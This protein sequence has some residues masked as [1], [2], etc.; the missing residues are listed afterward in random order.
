LD[1]GEVI[2][3]NQWTGG[4]ELDGLLNAEAS[5]VE[6][7][8]FD[9]WE[10]T[11]ATPNPDNKAPSITLAVEDYEEIV[12]YFR[13]VEFA[14]Y[15][16]TAFSPNNDGLNDA[17]LPVGNAFKTETY[18]LVVMNR[19]GEVVFESMDPEEPWIGQYQSGD[20]F[21][22]DGLYMFTLEVQSVHELAVRRING[23]VSVVR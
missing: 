17:F 20:H 5:P 6:F 7:W 10:T 15:V 1:G 14:I 8:E 12:A 3:T 21:V 16:P 22:R 11:T 2:V 18:H 19:W 23:S 4:L 13:P 9:H